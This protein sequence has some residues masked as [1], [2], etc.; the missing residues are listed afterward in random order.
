MFTLFT[1]NPHA[2][3]QKEILSRGVSVEAYITKKIAIALQDLVSKEATIQAPFHSCSDTMQ[4]IF[5]YQPLIVVT[6]MQMFDKIRRSS[7]HDVVRVAELKDVLDINDVQTYVINSATV[8]FL[9]E[10][11]QQRG[12]GVSAVKASSSSYNCESCN[13]AL[14]DPFRFCSL[15][16]NLK[17]IKEDMRTNIPTRDFIDYTRKDDDTDCSN[18]SGNTGNNEESCSD[19]NYCKEKPSP[20]RVIRHRRKGIPQRAPF[21]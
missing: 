3:S 1:S 12:C 2:K 8:V 19:A 16:C 4:C 11:P 5:H 7:Y 13:R 9:N 20:P 14:L 10:R 6:L 18:T 21:Y 17:G 15:G